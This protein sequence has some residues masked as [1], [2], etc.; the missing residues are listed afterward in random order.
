M[1]SCRIG[2]PLA[3]SLLLSG[4][5][6]L[7]KPLFALQYQAPNLRRAHT[8]PDNAI[9]QAIL[10][11][12]P[13][14]I[15]IIHSESGRKFTY[16]SLLHDVAIAKDRLLQTANGKPLGGERIAF[17]AENG[18]DYVGAHWILHSAEHHLT[19]EQ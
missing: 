11:H 5:A 15:A 4:P 18:Y 6:G 10:K 12:D 9:F 8:M 7:Q 17:L 13:E 3:R 19:P 2:R 14:R 1:S 16:G